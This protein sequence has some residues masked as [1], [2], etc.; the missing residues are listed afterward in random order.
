MSPL[1]GIRHWHDY[2]SMGQE[3]G[4]EYNDNNLS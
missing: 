1:G 3:E 2:D 4:V